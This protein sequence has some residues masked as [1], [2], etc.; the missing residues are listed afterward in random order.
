MD[1]RELADFLR[2][3]RERLRPHEVGLTAGPR[4]RTPGLR[5]E[6]LAQLAG[7][8]A[9]Y[10]MRMEQARSPQPS[11]H[12]LAS[13]ARALRLDEDERDHLYLLAGHRPPAGRQ[14]G[15][16][17]RPG[18]LYLLD[19][20]THTPAQILN[21]LGDVLAQ[22]AMAQALLGSVCAVRKHD[23]GQDHNFVWRWFL[24][25][26]A[27]LPYPPDEHEHYGRRYVADLRAV[28][29][30]RGYDGAVT[31]LVNRLRAASDEFD[32]LWRR[33][34]VAVR[35]STR[36][37]LIHPTIGPLEFD[38]ETLLT[39]AEDQRLLVYTAPPGTPT[40]QN[41]E[42]LRVVGREHF[43]PLP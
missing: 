10:Y 14:A 12:V 6:E 38:C 43:Q 31:G 29:A 35:H 28:A 41:L 3:S 21:D 33:H 17:L 32:A 24:D 25:P 34:E 7:V 11:T 8:S 42:L 20:L 4:R 37:R 22:N 36:M 40:A 5:R 30:R 16:H 15:N 19:Q 9:D 27:R 39:P 26:T 18:L 13:L 23:C 1:R 2:R